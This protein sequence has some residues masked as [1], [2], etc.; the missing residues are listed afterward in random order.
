MDIPETVVHLLS[1]DMP[2]EI[3]FPTLPGEATE[4]KVTEVG[5][6]AGEGNAFPVKVR[7]IDPSPEVRSGMTAEATFELR[8]D[9]YAEGYTVPSSAVVP[10]TE[11]NRGFVF[12]YQANSS[13]VK[14][15]PVEWGGVRD[16]MIV[17]SKGVSEGDNRGGGGREL[18]ERRLEG[19][20]HG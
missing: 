10:T 7:L 14:Q 3:I 13:T 17:I 16:N 2:A 1:V 18:P 19:G 8:S 6:L 15:T 5:T 9:E 11:P 4:G 12:V 20:A